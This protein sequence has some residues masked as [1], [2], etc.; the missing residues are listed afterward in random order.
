MVLGF[1]VGSHLDCLGVSCT[2][3][4]I[5]AIEISDFSQI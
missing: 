2:V 1:L 5:S 3:L 4:E